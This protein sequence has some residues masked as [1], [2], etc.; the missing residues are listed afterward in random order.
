MLH[1]AFDDAY[2]YM[3]DSMPTLKQLKLM[4]IG[5]EEIKITE[6]TCNAWK[7]M[8]ELLDFD[9]LGSKVS[10][11]E[12][13]T[14]GLEDCLIKVLRLWMKGES[15][16]YKPASWRTFIKLLRDSGHQALAKKIGDHFK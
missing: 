2:V 16:A 4:E 6:I 14:C 15:R 1:A 8:G 11:I 13:E 12:K 7:T 9:D 3:L 10:T 5:S